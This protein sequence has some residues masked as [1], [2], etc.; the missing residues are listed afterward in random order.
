ME[1][2]PEERA[3]QEMRAKIRRD[4]LER[5]RLAKERQQHR[6]Q[7]QQHSHNHAQ[8]YSHRRPYQPRVRP[9]VSFY[10]SPG[11][12]STTYYRYPS[13]AQVFTVPV[14]VQ[15]QPS[16][17]IKRRQEAPTQVTHPH[18]YPHHH[19]A[20]YN[21]YDQQE[22]ARMQAD[23]EQVQP[24]QLVAYQEGPGSEVHYTRVVPRTWPFFRL[25]KSTVEWKPLR[26]T[27]QIWSPTGPNRR[28][29]DPSNSIRK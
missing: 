16:R 21:L 26:E 6:Q 14:Q 25:P 24:G 28:G 23:L 4:R 8:D 3:E 9:Q 22:C 18:H 11:L 15:N 2:T 7:N 19:Q 13:A 17:A 20:Y 12:M 29:N 5:E 10:P 1:P 27:K